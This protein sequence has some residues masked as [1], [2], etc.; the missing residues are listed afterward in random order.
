M[1]VFD[2]YK[3]KTELHAHTKPVSACSEIEPERLI[4]LY[5]EK[6]ADAVCI[7]NHFSPYYFENGTKT[8]KIKE[9]IEEFEKTRKIGEKNGINVILGM[10]IRFTEN[11]ND[12]LVYGIGENELEYAYEFLDKG[13]D[14]FYKAFKNDSNVILQAHPFR[15]GMERANIKSID[16]IEVFNMHLNHNSR[17]SRAAQ[18]ATENNL[19]VSGGTDFHHETHQGQCFVKTDFKPVDSFDIAKIIKDSNFVFDIGGSIAVPYNF[20]G[21]I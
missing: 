14:E 21:N 3:F 9:Y 12:Y 16:G 11:A 1:K 19:L 4:E 18:Y 6:Q 7:T 10:E 13:I 2:K 20:K 17:V 15:D 5:K 8:E